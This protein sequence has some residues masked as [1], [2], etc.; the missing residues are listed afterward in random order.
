MPSARE[1]VLRF[2]FS[3]RRRHTRSKRDWSSD[4]C[5]SDLSEHY[6]TG[7]GH[8]GRRRYRRRWG[9]RA[10]VPAAPVWPQEARAGWWAPQQVVVRWWAPRGCGYRRRRRRTWAVL[11]P[12]GRG[13]LGRL[14]GV[15]VPPGSSTWPVHCRWYPSC[16]ARSPVAGQH[17]GGR[18]GRTMR[19]RWATL[20]GGPWAT[21]D[22]SGPVGPWLRAVPLPIRSWEPGPGQRWAQVCAALVRNGADAG[23]PDA[24]QQH[25]IAGQGRRPVQRH[26]QVLH[27]N[28]EGHALGGQRYG[29]KCQRAGERFARAA[30]VTLW[31]ADTVRDECVRI[32]VQVAEPIGVETLRL[33]RA[34]RVV[35]RAV[36]IEYRQITWL[37]RSPLRLVRRRYSS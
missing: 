20:I 5:S 14:R 10:A 35:V 6:R 16:D 31:P 15:R 1:L 7:H 12:W 34:L 2:F 37:E 8:R 17:L 32:T 33:R 19:H 29:L 26:G 4:V 9:K 30:M 11:P 13:F 22:V 23:R 36:Q 25:S 24:A 3:S 18:S 28:L 27:R 21:A